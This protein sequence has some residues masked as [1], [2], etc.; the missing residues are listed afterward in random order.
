[1]AL[2]HVSQPPVQTWSEDI[3]YIYF[4]LIFP[5]YPEFWTHYK[6]QYGAPLAAACISMSSLRSLDISPL[7]EV[8][9]ANIFSIW[10][11]A[12][13]FCWWLLLLCR[14]YLDWCSPINL[15]LLLLPS[16]WGSSSKKSLYNQFISLVVMFISMYFIVSG[17][18]FKS[19]N[20]SELTFV[21][22]VK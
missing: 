11:V 17:L 22:G 8:L 15:F 12:F 19:L 7:S 2:L 16:F 14:S 5:G 6:S 20:Y 3:L 4:F 21:Y 13:L 1:M 9:F 18:M 10:L